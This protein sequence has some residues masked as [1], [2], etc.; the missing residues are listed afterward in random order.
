MYKG[1]V[2]LTAKLTDN[3]IAFPHSVAEQCVCGELQVCRS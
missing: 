2:K 3:T 1:K